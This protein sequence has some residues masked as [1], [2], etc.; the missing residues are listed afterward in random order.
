[1]SLD[2][3]VRSV[4]EIKTL[5]SLT[6]GLNLSQRTENL[7]DSQ[8]PNILN[9]FFRKD[10]VLVDTGYKDFL[11][12][13]RGVPRAEIQFF[14]T[15]GSDIPCL[16]TNATFYVKVGTQW[17]YPSGGDGTATTMAVAGVATN[18]TIQVANATGFANDDYIAIELD[19][20]AQH[21]TRVN[22]A[23]VGN[24]ITIDDALPSGSAIGKYVCKAPALLGSDDEQVSFVIAS[25]VNW[26]IFTNGVDVLQRFDGTSVEAVPGTPSSGNTIC[27][28]V[29]LYRNYLFMINT[30]EGGT[31]RPQRVRWSGI[32]NFISWPANNLVDLVDTEDQAICAYPLG[33]YLIIYKSTTIVR[34]SFVGLS[35]KT[36]NFDV[37]ITTEGVN[38]VQSVVQLEKEHVFFGQ[39]GVF[40]YKG[41]MDITE[42]GEPVWEMLFGTDS[43][44]NPNFSNRIIGM[45]IHD[46][47]EVWFHYPDTDSEYPNN[48]LRYIVSE[49]VWLK[50][51]FANTVSGYGFYVVTT[52]RTWNDLIGDWTVQDWIWGS[53][54]VSANSPTVLLLNDENLQVYEY[55]YLSGDD[56]GAAISF[57]F[58]T[59]EFYHPD[60]LMRFDSFMIEAKGSAVT[61]EYSTDRG[62]TWITIAADYALQASYEL[63]NLGYQFVANRIRFRFR[64]S[65]SGFGIRWFA[66]RWRPESVH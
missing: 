51:Q 33:P 21:Q 32:A 39:G 29:A 8:S 25:S 47:N 16:I 53:S 66:F 62:N 4:W 20:G 28:A 6:G 55:D 38:G 56:D 24:V 12:V 49:K 48:T 10:E 44:L 63:L 45:F 43:E 37:V 65:G 57:E 34:A 30:V 15:D 52:T 1:M 17:Q 59:K 42:L 31:Y 2:S 9:L 41:G 7:E 58:Q 64:G 54:K 36:F 60:N 5:D 22:G 3:D 35:T 27:K 13:V 19:T 61:F 50:R 23:P 14:F 18:T 11:G 46:L 40:S 26:L